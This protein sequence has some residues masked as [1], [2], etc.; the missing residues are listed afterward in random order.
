MK[1]S[2]ARKWISEIVNA[3]VWLLLNFASIILVSLAAN[4]LINDYNGNR[5]ISISL[6]DYS[7]I[8]Y[9][10]LFNVFTYIFGLLFNLPNEDYKELL[11]QFVERF[12]VHY[13]DENLE[14]LK[15]KSQSLI[16]NELTMPKIKAMRQTSEEREGKIPLFKK[17]CNASLLLSAIPSLICIIV[18][19]VLMSKGEANLADHTT[20]FGI[21]TGALVLGFFVVTLIYLF[22]N[23]MFSRSR[24]KKKKNKRKQGN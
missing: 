22:W 9:S 5:S 7:L 23:H 18:Y 19:S 14:D 3:I 10:I 1:H 20:Y 16:S 13:S 15:K 6:T 2:T 8:A 12:V 4:F 11:A 21:I 17:L 24:K